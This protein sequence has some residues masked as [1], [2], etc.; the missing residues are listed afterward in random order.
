[1]G[2]YIVQRCRQVGSLLQRKHLHIV[3]LAV[4][5]LFATHNEV[6]YIH[7]LMRPECGAGGLS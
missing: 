5:S 1:M 6:L 4:A 2:A 3:V 7:S